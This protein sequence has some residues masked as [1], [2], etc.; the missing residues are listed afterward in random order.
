MKKLGCLI[1]L[2]LVLF[3]CTKKEDFKVVGTVTD[4]DLNGKSIYLFK[5]DNNELVRSDT[6]TIENGVFEFTGEELDPMV[7]Y[8]LMDDED[9]G[10]ITQGVPL[11][12]KPGTITV[13]IVGSKVMIGGNN[14]NDAYQTMM[15]AQVPLIEKIQFLDSQFTSG[16]V[17]KSMTAEKQADLEAQMQGV[18]ENVR[19]LVVDYVLGNMGNAMGEEVF[20]THLQLLTPEEVRLALNASSES[21]KSTPDVQEILA[22]MEAEE[23]VSVG[24]IYTDFSL[25]DANGKEVAL[26]DFAGKGKYVLVDFWASWCMPC[27]KEMPTLMKAYKEYQDKNFEIVGISLDEDRTAWLN[28]VKKLQISWPQLSDLKGC[29]PATTPYQVISIPHTILLDPDGKIIAKNLRGEELVSK[30]EEVLL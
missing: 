21:F 14:E 26:S 20:L 10:Q 3:A 18:Y 13:D 28:S 23:K 4:A 1:T 24:K 11:F 12:I 2:V 19:K 15:D 5:Y 16:M 27:I 29:L 8:I 7:Y 25:P 30:L 6:T 9:A 22:V 17:D